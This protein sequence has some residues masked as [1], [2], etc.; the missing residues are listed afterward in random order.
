MCDVQGRQE[1]VEAPAMDVSAFVDELLVAVM[2]SRIYWPEHPRVAASVVA[3]RAALPD[4]ADTGPKSELL[5]GAAHGYL[6]HKGRPLVG[7]SL[8]APRMIQTLSALGAGGLGFSARAGE[9]DLYAL[10]E[11]LAARKPPKGY[12][13]ANLFLAGRGCSGIRVLPPYRDRRAASAVDMP[14]VPIGVYQ[15]VVDHLQDSIV[16]VCNGDLI[17]L[18]DTDGHVEKILTKVRDETGEMLNTSRYERYDAFTFG[19]SIRVCVL[20]LQFASALTDDLELVRRI[21][22]AALLHDVGKARVPF[23]I[24]HSTGKLSDEERMEMNRH[25]EHGGEI[26]LGH[27]PA[28][29][30]AV[31][32]AFCHHRTEDG[33]GYPRTRASFRLS[34]ATRIVKICDVFEALTAVRPYKDRMTPLRAYRVMMSMGKH[35]DRALLR[36]FIGVHGLY[37][38]GSKVCLDTGHVVPIRRQ[39]RRVDQP[40][41]AF[42]DT[43]EDFHLERRYAAG[44]TKIVRAIEPESA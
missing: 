28:D 40:L 16:R 6:F 24:L 14:Q 17:R 5:F 27:D 38:N 30:L 36:R 3:L 13:E 8:S 20:T 35:F 22:K 42:G 37:P 10:I 19:H 4:L 29:P 11:L 34:M 41:L 33:G 39:G 15:Q 1:G 7:P 31:A 2:N 18:E 26:L 23:E 32:A 43:A 25:V 12:V 44:Q 9:T 21:G